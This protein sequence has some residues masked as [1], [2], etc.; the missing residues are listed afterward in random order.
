MAE[1]AETLEVT[2]CASLFPIQF[3]D[4]SVAPF[5][6]RFFVKVSADLA[7][8]TVDQA[9]YDRSSSVLESNSSKRATFSRIVLILQSTCCLLLARLLPHGCWSCG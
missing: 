4:N 8:G 5:F 6:W 1:Y 2:G 3:A 9:A 7:Q